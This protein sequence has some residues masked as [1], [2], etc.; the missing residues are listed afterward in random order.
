MSSKL[1]EMFSVKGKRNHN[2]PLE[3]LTD[4]EFEISQHIGQGLC[5]QE[6]AQ[7][8]RLNVKT[9]EVHPN[10]ANRSLS[11]GLLQNCCVI[12]FVGSKL[13]VLFNRSLRKSPKRDR[14]N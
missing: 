2:S 10:N 9:V 1:L 5:T 4:R 12:P 3:K 7:K 13:K 6:I 11:L 14:R 8:L